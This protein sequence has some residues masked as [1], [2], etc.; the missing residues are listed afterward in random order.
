MIFDQVQ[1]RRCAARPRGGLAGRVL[2]LQFLSF[3]ER[4]KKREYR[5]PAAD[6]ASPGIER[7]FTCGVPNRDVC[8]DSRRVSRDRFLCFVIRALGDVHARGR[9]TRARG[10]HVGGGQGAGGHDRPVVRHHHGPWRLRSVRSSSKQLP[11]D[12][13]AGP[14]NNT[15][16]I[17]TVSASGRDTDHIQSLHERRARLSLVACH[18]PIHWRMQADPQGD[19]K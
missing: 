19:F 6:L 8:I 9:G 18:S 2:L 4:K 11:F 1:R 5:A 12:T 10:R 14:R 7:P 3:G 16:T 13:L 15:L 17:S